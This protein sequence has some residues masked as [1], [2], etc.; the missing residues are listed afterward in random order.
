MLISSTIAFIFSFLSS[1]SISV[2]ML[3][4]TRFFVG[5]FICGVSANS[6]AYLG[7]FFSDSVRAKYINLCSVFMAFALTLSPSLGWIF[8]KLD[9]NAFNNFSMWRVFLLACSLIS[10]VIAIS[11]FFLAESPKFLLAKQEDEEALRVLEKIHKWNKGGNGVLGV[12]KIEFNEVLLNSN[13]SQQNSSCWTKTAPIF[14]AP[15]LKS[16]LKISFLMFS[17]FANSSGFFMWTPDILNQILDYPNLTV[18]E[19][20]DLVIISRENRTLTST[21]EGSHVNEK[22]YEITFM[23]GCF[24]SLIY[25]INAFVISKI[26][27]K[28]L[29]ALWFTLCAISSFLIPF[30]RNYYV[31]LFLLLIFLTSGVCGAIVSSIIVDIYPTYVR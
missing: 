19:V 28:Q 30:F 21:C 25:F 2:W 15:L 9:A 14:K 17:F 8:L 27:K 5:F 29:L 11:L 23:M 4:L 24:F 16:T 31:I 22:I 12:T 3:I 6:Y 13:S 1:F 7:E 10:L 20:T 18:C 26:G